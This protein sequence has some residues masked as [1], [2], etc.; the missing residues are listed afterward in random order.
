MPFS[1]IWQLYR[2]THCPITQTFYYVTIFSLYLYLLQGKS[3]KFLISL[4]PTVTPHLSFLFSCTAHLQASVL[5]F[6]LSYAAVVVVQFINSRKTSFKTYDCGGG[7]F[8]SLETS[9]GWKHL[10]LPAVGTRP[11]STNSKCFIQNFFF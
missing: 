2:M 8:L 10:G 5:M 1:V 11:C 9:Y 4:C 3:F 7:G 6:R